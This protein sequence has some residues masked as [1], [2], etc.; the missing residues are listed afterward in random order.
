MVRSRRGRHEGSLRERSDGRWEARV[1][2][3]YDSSGGRI[4]R[5]VYGAT[6]QEVLDKLAEIRIAPVATRGTNP[7]MTLAEFAP[8]WMAALKAQGKLRENTIAYYEVHI[9]KHASPVIGGLQLTK[10]KPHNV[11]MLLAAIASARTREA[12]YE[13]LRS[14]Y[15]LAER[16]GLVSENP[17]ARI[18]KPK[19]DK[20]HK[21]R[22]WTPEEARKFM[23][24]AASSPYFGVYA[25]ALGAGLRRGEIFALRWRDVDLDRGTVCI[26]RT[27]IEVSGKL[28]F[29]EPKT[30]SSAR[31]VEL[32]KMA[33]D[34][35]TRMTRGDADALIFTDSEAGPIRRSNFDRRVHAPLLATAG[36]TRRTMH[37][38][39]HSHASIL[40]AAGE[41]IRLVSSRLGHSTINVT[42]GV[43]SHLM[44][45]ADRAA[46]TKIDEAFAVQSAG[47][48]PKKSL[49]GSA[50]ARPQRRA[51]RRQ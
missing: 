1:S 45:G 36:V 6:K 47:R 11:E 21:V 49:R 18:P 16:R 43:Y 14:M 13:A 19:R 42:L 46:A 20:K 17:L 15:R 31:T 41:S 37:E 38:L 34:A 44:P 48:E 29:G 24:A 4:Q 7:K 25:L 30:A 50:S 39:R 27:L 10:I 51:L 35:L 8:Q 26:E 3:G 2:L 40:I 5:S 9:R 23:T 32:P 28:S 22:I 12:T 33:L